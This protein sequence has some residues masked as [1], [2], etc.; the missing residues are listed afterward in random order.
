MRRRFSLLMVMMWVLSVLVTPGVTSAREI[1][2]DSQPETSVRYSHRL[3]VELQTPSLS[4][5]WAAGAISAASSA[6]GQLD[7]ASATAQ[8][9]VQQLQS[10]QQNFVVALQAAVPDAQVAS[11]INESGHSRPEAV[12]IVLNAVVVD[13]GRDAD[14]NALQRR[15]S[16]LPG[17]KRVSRDRAIEPDLYAG[18]P[19]IN[20]AAAWNNAAIGGRGN[21]GAGIKFAS[22]D[23]GAHHAAPMFDGTG[24]SY[25]PGYPKGDPKNNNGKIIVSRAY[26]RPWDPPAAGD[27]N[28]WPGTHGTPHGTHTSSTAAGNEIVASYRGLT[29]TISGVAPRAYVM[30]YRV[31]YA[32]VNGLSSFFEAEGLAALE[33]VVKDDADVLNNSWGNGPIPV[34]STYDPIQHALVNT[35]KA[36][37]FVSMSA[38]NEGPGIGTGDHPADEYINVAA[39]TTSGTLASG[40]FNVTA[41]AP[42]PDSLVGLSFAAAAFGASL[43]LGT[44]IGP[45]DYL[46]AAAVD[47]ANADG[48]AAF[49]E[50]A[51]D[52][53]AAVIIRGA[54]E[55]GLKA[56][57]AQNAGAAFVVVYNS[58]AGGDGTTVMGPGVV[59]GQVTI[60]AIF[61]GNTNGANVVN[62]YTTHGSGA[63]AIDTVAYQAGN[64]PDR[65]ASFSSRG[66]SVN[67]TLKPD[68]AAPGVNILAQGY[69]DATGEARHL[70]YGQASGTSMASPHVAGSAVLLRQI[71]PDWSSAWIKSALMSTSKYLDMFN[72]DETPAQPLDMG[73]GR[74]DLTA[75]AEPGVILTPPS[76][77]FGGIVSGTVASLNVQVTSVANASETYSLSTVYTGNGFEQL[78][79]VAGLSVSPASLTLTPGETKT[80][81]VTWDTAQSLGYGDNQGYV[82]LDGS[83]HD[84][85][86]P[87]W[88]RVGYETP[89]ADVLII[90]NDGSSVDVGDDYTGYYT[91]TLEALG[92]SYE[93]WDADARSGEDNSIPDATVL[94][95]YPNIIYQTGDNYQATS[96]T[97]SDLDRLNEYFN[98]G[99]RLIA[100][101]QD[102]ASVT[103]GVVTDPNAYTQFYN[104]LL[105]ATWLQD[106]VNAENVFTDTAQLITGAPGQPFRNMSFDISARGDGAGNQGYVDEIARG[107]V[108]DAEYLA[109]T[110]FP[111]LKYAGG[112]NNV[113]DG[114]VAVSNRDQPTLERPGV[115]MIGRSLYFSFG[116][117]G[118]NSDTGFNTREDLLGAALDWANDSAS[119]A[120]DAKVNGLN[121][122]SMF[123]ATV[124]SNLGGDGASYR[125]DFGDGSDFT[126]ANASRFS[127]H[128]YTEAG[129]YTVRVEATNELGTRVLG[130]TQITIEPAE[131]VTVTLPLVA[132]TWVNGGEQG[133]NYN[134]FAA[135]IGRTTGLDNVLL[136]F[137]RSLLP[138]GAEIAGAELN[139]NFSGQSGQF[140]KTLVAS[141]VNPFDPAT[142]TYATAPLIYN[143]GAAVAA[144]N[145]GAQVVFDVASQVAA[146]DAA[147]GAQAAGSMGRLAI[148]SAGPGGRVIMDSLESFQGHPATL[149]VTYRPQ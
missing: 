5:A 78:A 34:N 88:A 52:G 22:V 51:F 149:T 26:F 69:A 28:T 103:G 104:R 116:L 66:P 95:R 130:E 48:C 145:A 125:W 2:A 15:L 129:N 64:T 139:V 9:Y 80:V 91:S 148:S 136:A 77:S 44:I 114:F 72:F 111:I 25:P 49:P 92:R 106:S 62:W 43:P 46:P 109:H 39:S 132:D 99:G 93:V 127:G 3:I 47:P 98:G 142:V 120:I 4:E 58:V 107:F 140:G 7:V 117:E 57:N 27:Q 36:G 79:P 30:S 96:L 37:V 94:A 84:A 123:T 119:A 122:V 21:A 19:L 131:A 82:V 137:D 50:G 101:G 74:L 134:A 17:V 102:L 55:F 121:A 147:G 41:P 90:D 45:Y 56:L 6:E 11:F 143:P 105:G 40:R 29:E 60:G 112:S 61:I 85:H 76:L 100:L 108:Q 33:D 97:Q 124:T 13:A 87:A 32:S 65:I 20:A 115:T 126:D 113:E 83:A 89:G 16:R 68:I 53:K 144:P 70:G 146:W 73:A 118:V 8:Q 42:V 110:S 141:N 54:C 63:F 67:L 128:T 35:W 10:E 86:L 71:H 81:T 31:F 12:Q 23:G 135:L 38:G 14:V 75:A 1:G 24:Y 133:T 59:G 18:L 138:A